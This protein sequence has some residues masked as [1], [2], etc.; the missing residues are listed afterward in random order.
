M[1]STFY[2]RTSI[3]YI[4]MSLVIISLNQN[5][6]P[7]IHLSLINSPPHLPPHS[8]LHHSIQLALVKVDVLVEQ[9]VCGGQDNSNH[10]PAP[11]HVQVVRGG[12]RER[13]DH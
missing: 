3:V 2:N 6:V 13:D 10:P 9:V 4:I 7:L 8:H 12:T 5:I 11:S 1:G